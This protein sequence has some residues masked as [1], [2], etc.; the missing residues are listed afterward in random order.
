MR[1]QKKALGDMIRYAYN[2]TR[3]YRRVFDRIHIDPNTD[4][5]DEFYSCIPVT[6]KSDYYNNKNDFISDEYDN[7]R[8]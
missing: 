7:I 6:T 8:P 1:D 3:Y 4:E 5:I 2:H